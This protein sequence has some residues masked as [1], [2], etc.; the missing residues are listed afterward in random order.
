MSILFVDP[1]AH[2]LA[3]NFFECLSAPS[4][5]GGNMYVPSPAPAPTPAGGKKQPA[6]CLLILL[7]P[8]FRK[9]TNMAVKKQLSCLPCQRCQLH[10]DL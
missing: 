7:T 10:L 1:L 2:Q 3:T 4:P 9:A 8:T 6:K 5:V